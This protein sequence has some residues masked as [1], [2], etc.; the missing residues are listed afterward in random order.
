MKTGC[1]CPALE[2]SDFFHRRGASSLQNGTLAVVYYDF[3]NFLT[4]FLCS[5]WRDD[6]NSHCLEINLLYV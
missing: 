4:F 2:F 3:M 5:V 1:S 6:P